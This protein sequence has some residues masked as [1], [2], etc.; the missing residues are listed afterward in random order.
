MTYLTTKTRPYS[1]MDQLIDSMFYNSPVKSQ[2]SRAFS[3]DVVE[4]DER[5]VVSA[6]L[7]GFAESD[8]EVTV[9]DNLMV[10]SASK[11]ADEEAKEEKETKYL[12]RERVEGQYKRSFNLPKDADRDDITATLKDGILNL[13]IA[14]K[15]EAKPLSIKIN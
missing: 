10:I 11:K 3:V 9:N 5:Y 2:S 7:P 14:K 13:A 1:T 12:L 4:E 6:E 15:P 8:I